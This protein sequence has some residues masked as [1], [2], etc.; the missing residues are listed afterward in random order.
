MA[1]RNLRYSWPE[2]RKQRCSNPADYFLLLIHDYSYFQAIV[3]RSNACYLFER[4]GEIFPESCLKKI[5]LRYVCIIRYW[6]GTRCKIFLSL[7]E[8][9]KLCLPPFR[10]I[11]IRAFL[12]RARD[13]ISLRKNEKNR[14]WRIRGGSSLVCRQVKWND[15]LSPTTRQRRDDPLFPFC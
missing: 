9:S 1:R 12:L 8:N 7:S 4:R 6:D 10:K 15:M 14:R 11:R 2:I 5:L 3:R 13:L